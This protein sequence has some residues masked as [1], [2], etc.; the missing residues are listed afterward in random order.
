MIDGHRILVVVP[1]RGGSQGVKLKNLREV[2]GVPLVARVGAVVRALSLIDRAVVST[3]HEEIARV[4]ESSGLEAPFRR[5]ES[6]SGPRI[7]DLEVLTHATE[8]ME[9]RDGC[10]YDVIVMLQPTSPSRTPEHVERT[11]H[12]L[13]E[14]KLDATWTVSETDSKAH[15]LKQMTISGDGA[16][17]LYDQAGATIIARQQL[18]PVYHRNGIAYAFRRKTLLEDKT[19]LPARTGA[20]VIEGE[21]ANIDTELDLLWAN[22]LLERAEKI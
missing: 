22:F 11:I 10:V 2:G 1:A 17:G 14:E 13:I 9:R 6:L 7:G 4:A 15:P 16:L 18:Q 12:R 19:I 5:P 20:I 21:V 3:D 8:E